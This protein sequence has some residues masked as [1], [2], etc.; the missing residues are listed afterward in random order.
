VYIEVKITSN[1][2]HS[3]ITL[4][5]YVILDRKLFKYRSV[6]HVYVNVPPYQQERS[7]HRE[8]ETNIGEGTLTHMCNTYS[9]TTAC[10]GKCY[11]SQWTLLQL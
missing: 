1:F 11:S 5:F 7:V 2:Y 10:N 9:L 4:L 8:A 3:F 6:I